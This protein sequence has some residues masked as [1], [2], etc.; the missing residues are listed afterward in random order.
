M[1]RLAPFLL[2]CVATSSTTLAAEA[3]HRHRGPHVHGEA[4][5]NIGMDGALLLVSLEAP[6]MSLLGF[7][8]PLHDDAERAAYNKALVTLKS[9]KW[10]SLPEGA[11]CVLDSTD[12]LPHG[13]DL[14]GD[15]ARPGEKPG[16]HEHADFDAT[17]RY[18]CHAP[19]ALHD[20]DV[21]LFDAFPDL[22]KV[23]VELVLPNRE[24]SQVLMPGS[25][26]V[27]LSK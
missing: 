7:E 6:G 27:P 14:K 22:H 9:A 2:V 21:R 10:L 13:F 1:N 15:A 17:Y 16:A 25:T 20:L 5:L 18:T 19:L 23:N 4:T 11:A 12:V 8:H 26:L 3:V 24:G